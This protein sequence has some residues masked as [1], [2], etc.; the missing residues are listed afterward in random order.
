MV[1]RRLF[2]LT[3]DLTRD[4]VLAIRGARRRPGYAVVVI[5]TLAI[6]IGA[7]TAIY[8]VFNW[9][10]FRPLPGVHAPAELVTIKYQTA[11]RTGSYFLSYRD[12]ADVRDSVTTSVAEIAAAAPQRVDLQVGSDTRRIQAEVVSTNYFSLLGV[13]PLFGR[14]FEPREEQ[15]G[16]PASVIVSERLLRTLGAGPAVVGTTVRVSGRPFAIIGVAPARFSGRSPMEPADLWISISGYVTLQPAGSRVSS[17]MTSRRYMLFGDALARLRPGF[18]IDHAQAEADAAIA[19][20]PEFATGF[21]KP[22]QRS[23]IAPILYPGIGHETTTAEH[24]SRLFRLLIGAV[25]L[26]LVLACANASNVLLARATARRREIAVCQAIGASRTRIIRQQLVEGLALALVAGALGLALAVWLTSLFDGMRIMTAL[27]AVHAIQI[28]WRVCAFAASASII[29]GVIFASVPAV[30]SSR[31]DLLSALKHAPGT[32]RTGRHLLRGS[33]VTLQIAI[34]MLLL[35]GAGLFIRTLHNIRSLDLGI[36]TDDVVSL[37]VQPSRFGL[38]SE[39]SSAYVTELLA[40]LRGAPGVSSAAFART[41]SFS[42][43]RADMVFATKGVGDRHLSARESAVSPG[44]FATMKIPLIA[45]RDFRESDA[46]V[47]ESAPTPVIISRRLAQAAFPNGGAV[48]AQLPL[49]YPK[50]GSAL[51][52]GITNDV[53]GRAVTHDPE[54]WVYTPARPLAGTILVRSSLPEDQVIATVK[55]IAR[56]IDPIVAPNDIEPFNAAVDRAIAEERLFARLAGAFALVAVGLA[57]TGIHAVMAGA[58]AERRKEFGIRLALGAS[59]AAVVS[60]VFGSVLRLAAMGVTLG[61]LGAYAVRRTIESRLYG[62]TAMDPA[63]VTVTMLTI[64]TL[65]ILASLL[66]AAWAARVDPVRSLRVEE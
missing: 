44:Y 32:S 61:I 43:N 60:L 40:R 7:N 53:R 62:V 23:N 18:T 36:D 14:D 19:G 9:I 52:V 4:V 15:P 26:L 56:S 2:G 63:T 22:G 45:G 24:L 33:L 64:V 49:M 5:A 47:P 12:Y 28:D 25:A 58:V 10:L 46:G 29:T 54:P 3:R 57:L 8:S 42:P 65:C 1:D 20:N 31:V 39:R 66:P 13:R 59:G 37:T 34:S 48:G 16:G 6:G 38:N 21:S 51:V 35:V 55:Q 41:H 27:P 17:I 11:K 30:A 50:G